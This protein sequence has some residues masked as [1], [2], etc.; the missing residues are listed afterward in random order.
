MERK[1][2]K[3]DK[4]I[5]EKKEKKSKKV[6]EKAVNTR[7][8]D[9][10]QRGI[11]LQENGLEK[12]YEQIC[13]EFP[14][15]QPGKRLFSER[16]KKN[17]W[18]KI[19][20]TV[21][22]AVRLKLDSL[23]GVQR[24]F[25]YIPKGLIAERGKYHKGLISGR[26]V[27][28]KGKALPGIGRIDLSGAIPDFKMPNATFN[29]P[30]KIKTADPKNWSIMFLN[31]S[32]LGIKYTPDIVGNAVRRALSDA[33]ERKDAAVILTNLI[34]MDLKKAGGP[35]KAMRAQ[36]YGDNINPE[37]VQDPDYK[38]T[39]EHILSE[40]PVDKIIYRTP[41]ELLN[42]LLGG[43]IKIGTK[44]AKVTKSGKEEPEYRGP[45]YI[46]FGLNE[47]ALITAITYWEIRWWTIKEQARL[48]G[49]IKIAKQGLKAAEKDHDDEKIKEWNT[50][51]ESLEYQ[52]AITTASAVANQEF[53]RFF[54]YAQSVVVQKFESAIPNSKV[55]GQNTNYIEVNGEK[56]EIRIPSS[57]RV[58][59]GLLND[60]T[61][62]YAP[63]VLRGKIVKAA[64]ICHPWAV[65]FRATGREIDHDGKRDSMK[66]Y[67]APIAVDDEFL[68]Q[69]LDSGYANVH[70]LLK[71]VYSPTF[72]AG[73]LRLCS[74]NGTIDAD[75]VPV[76]ALEAYKKYPAVKKN[77]KNGSSLYTRGPKYIWI[78]NCSDQH[79]GGRAREFMTDKESGMRVGVAEA[80][81]QMMRRAGLCEGSNMRVHMF[82]SPDDPTQGYLKFNARTQ[83]HPHQM[84]F[85]MIEKA[86]LTFLQKAKNSHSLAAKDEFMEKLHNLLIYQLEKR[87]SDYLLEQMLQMMTRHIEA[88]ADAFSAILKRAQNANLIV[89]GVGHYVNAE[90]GGY[91]TRNIG[92]INIGSGNHF[93][94]TLEGELA[95]GPLYAQ[96]LMDLL[97]SMNYWKDK[98]DLLEQLITSPFYSGECI[99]YG[100][101]GV[102]GK[103]EYGLELRASPTNMQGWGDPLRGHVH[104]DLQRGNYSRIFNNKLP[105]IKIMGDKHFFS[106]VITGYTVY[107]M[108][109]SAT[110][111]DRYGDRGFPPN[112]TGV[113][114]IGVPVDGP[115]SGPVIIRSLLFDKIKDYIENNPK[116][117]DWERF[118]PNP[119]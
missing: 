115:E 65:Q 14:D 69:Q 37:L 1:E 28:L 79:W 52:L 62:C 116:P 93:T 38:K 34:C 100:V 105:V 68:R 103:H 17:I 13:K 99:G 24:I 58:T 80:V 82:T 71:A 64:V 5:Q 70:P 73:V 4:S 48:R 9:I 50:S 45:V 29:E 27:K 102:K 40:L 94:N 101:I 36:I 60:Y 56:I 43:W 104:K 88:N 87:G 110:H 26:A 57:S 72:Q 117:F 16:V 3:K 11:L 107:H 42:D 25:P 54:N 10:I 44:P 51:L 20:K 106:S 47:K 113:S 55:I 95:E 63:E 61:S 97:L 39:V 31:G 119:A 112:N 81:F 30:L 22:E 19:D 90:F 35:A 23:E 41:E 12:L 32:D 2:E 85:N 7:I 15:K 76:K 77:D 74:T 114:F 46:V 86:A 109:P 84:P 67:V 118:L 59:D 18:A 6:L 111:T 8:T 108:C 96:K 89:K 33:D 78:L 49:E 66:V 98:K 83:P 91:D 92:V 75:A 21:Q 53:Q